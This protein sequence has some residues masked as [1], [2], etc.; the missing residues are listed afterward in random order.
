[1]GAVNAH[2]RQERLQ[3]AMRYSQLCRMIVA[4]GMDV[5]IATIS[6]FHEVHKWNRANLPDYAEIYLHVPL[7]ELRRRDPKQIYARAERGEIK[8][9][10]GVDFMVD[11]PYSPDVFIEWE[12]GLSVEGVLAH[13]VDQ[14]KL[15]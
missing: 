6:M 8:D 11:E 5:A 14:L 13:V 10:A 4:Q 2:T 1:M 9:V 15:N 7:D 12:W 3:L